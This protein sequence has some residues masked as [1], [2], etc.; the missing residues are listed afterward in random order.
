VLPLVSVRYVRSATFP[1]RVDAPALTSARKFRRFFLSG[2]DF[3]SLAF[4]S[5]GRARQRSEKAISG[6]VGHRRR[7]GPN[8]Y[9]A[10]HRC[11]FHDLMR[12]RQE[13]PGR[14]WM[15]PL[16]ASTASSCSGAGRSQVEGHVEPVG[17]TRRS[18]GSPPPMDR[19][20]Q[21]MSSR[22]RLI[23][24]TPAS[25]RYSSAYVPRRIHRS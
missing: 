21:V 3:I 6:Q 19:S 2:D 13:S 9:E 11:P 1:T 10:R 8:A 23:N 22:V 16:S 12:S 17:S 5:R 20:G 4:I 14:V 15:L 24:Q 25:R 7:S 18:P